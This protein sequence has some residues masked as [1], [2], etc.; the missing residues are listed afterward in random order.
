MSSCHRN[1]LGFVEPDH[2]FYAHN[3]VYE[4]IRKKSF[5]LTVQK[6]EVLDK[7]KD[8]PSSSD[9]DHTTALVNL[10]RKGPQIEE[11]KPVVEPVD[12][13]KDEIRESLQSLRAT[14]KT[15]GHKKLSTNS[16]SRILHS[17]GML[18]E[19]LLAGMF[20]DLGSLVRCVS[21]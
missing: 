19:T 21:F 12:N 5:A 6:K 8:A 3:P 4:S 9:L 7:P 18:C 2:N 14:I 10:P 17:T 16:G 20:L 1:I 15:L 11:I 13:P